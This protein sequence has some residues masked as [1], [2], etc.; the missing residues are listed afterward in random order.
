MIYKTFPA[1]E[2]VKDPHLLQLKPNL[3]HIRPGVTL[4]RAW[5]VKLCHL[6]AT[7]CRTASARKWSVDA[8]I[9]TEVCLFHCERDPYSINSTTPILLKSLALRLTSVTYSE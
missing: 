7:V 2:G 4:Y 6:T 5:L 3:V 9:N 8:D 1:L